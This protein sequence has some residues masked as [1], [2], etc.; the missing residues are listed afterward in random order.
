[1]TALADPMSKHS[2]TSS[3][4]KNELEDIVELFR[5]IVVEMGDLKGEL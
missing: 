3:D 5:E 4:A 1:M 2:A